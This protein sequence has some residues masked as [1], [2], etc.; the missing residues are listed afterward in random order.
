MGAN[1]GPRSVTNGM[2]LCLDAA[3]PNSNPW[4]H[5][6]SNIL[7]PWMN[8]TTGTDSTSG[9]SRNGSAGE[10][11]RVKA[12]AS[13]GSSSIGPSGDFVWA[14]TPDS[15]SGADGGWNSAY[16][17]IDRSFRYR[18]SVWVQRPSSA[19][20]GTFYMGLN[21]APIRNDNNS[22]QSNPYFTYPSQAS[23]TEKQWYLVVAHCHEENYSGGRHPDSGWYELSSTSNNVSSTNVLTKI[24]DKSFGN[25][26]DQDVRFA[27]STTQTMHRT[28]HFYTTNTSSSLRFAYP[29][30]DKCD[31]TEPSIGQLATNAKLDLQNI[32]ATDSQPAHG[33]SAIGSLSSKW[34]Y[35]TNTG[36]PAYGYNG[37]SGTSGMTVDLNLSSGSYTVVAATRYTGTPTGRIVS[38]RTNNWLLGHWG[39]TTENHYAAGW[40]T[41]SSSGPN[42]T[43][44]RIYV[45]TGNTSTDRYSFWVNGEKKI[46]NSTGGSQGPNGFGLFHYD[47]GNSEYSQGEI[48]YL[49][50]YNRVLS[51]SEVDTVYNSLKGRFGL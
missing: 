14:T 42:D 28:Y 7:N 51:D 27:S 12:F 43:N 19:T 9:Y 45:S 47:P 35:N 22:S 40:V 29:R 6:A 2:V 18:W 46:S 30:L 37:D 49:A 32:M 4:A 26:G 24:S 16:Y 34:N 20:G 3:N 50:A 1:A 8:W 48:A 15:T 39:S 17:N 13:S 10:Q 25:C 31:G 11:S 38:G 23:L 5:Q 44:W 21:P 36:T 33:T 41:S